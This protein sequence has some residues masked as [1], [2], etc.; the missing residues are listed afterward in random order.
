MK[1]DLAPADEY[2]VYSKG[3]ITSEKQTILTNLYQPIIGSNATILYL[4]L[5]NDL[6][7]NESNSYNHHHLMTLMQLKIEVLLDA[8]YRLEAI[9]L[10]KTYVKQGEIDKYM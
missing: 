6:K 4:T 8:R 1:I 5:L 2:T 9:G 7:K 10:L 3:I